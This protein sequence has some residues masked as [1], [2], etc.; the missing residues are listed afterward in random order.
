M[1]Y[2]VLVGFV[3]AQLH[4]TTKRLLPFFFWMQPFLLFFY[5][6]FISLINI[7]KRL[8]DVLHLLVGGGDGLRAVLELLRKVS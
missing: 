3:F 5:S 6:A 4:Y 2:N 1:L 8:I 7:V